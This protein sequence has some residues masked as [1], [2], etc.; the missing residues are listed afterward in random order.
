MQIK[1]K[2][3]PGT[4]SGEFW[5]SITIDKLQ[6]C[7]TC[8]FKTAIASELLIN[9]IQCVFKLYFILSS[10]HIIAMLLS[11]LCKSKQHVFY[12][13]AWLEKVQKKKM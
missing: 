12:T 1:V 2:S 7:V 6:L 9:E 10:H 8:D 13:I 5:N 4:F 3:S 11:C